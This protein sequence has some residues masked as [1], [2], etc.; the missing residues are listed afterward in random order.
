[1][2][3]LLGSIK[4]SIRMSATLSNTLDDGTSVSASQPYLNYTPTL[5]SGINA[6]QANRGWQIGSQVIADGAQHI[7]DLADFA[8]IDIGSG[9]GRDAVGQLIALQEIMSIAIVNEN[10]VGAA[11][12]LE[13][14]PASSEGWSPI[15]S[16]TVANGG[17]LLG[18][19]I[20]LKAQPAEAGFVIGENTHR[21][22]MRASGGDVT[23]SLYLKGRDDSDESSVSSLSSS[24]SSVSSASSLSSISTSSISTSSVSSSTSSV[25]SI[26]TSSVSSS[27][28]SASSLSTSSSS[29][30]SSSLSSMS[31]SST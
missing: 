16:H 17:A 24:S 9:E 4:L 10:A 21:I 28:S 20:L 12:S 6:N 11:G 1:M 19:G 29:Q 18:Q 30:S 5:T 22:M 13:I 31:S 7:I 25:S 23:F 3:R 14:L 26:S 8:G 15:G 2:T 27:T